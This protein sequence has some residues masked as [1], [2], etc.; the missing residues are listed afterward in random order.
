MT[1]AVAA[2]DLVHDIVS[3][4]NAPI[5]AA[6]SGDFAKYVRGMREIEQAGVK[7][8]AEADKILEQYEPVSSL[9][10]SLLPYCHP[11][12]SS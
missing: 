9:R 2:P 4:D 3:V 12:L 11:P 10:A 8:Q 5:D 1:I 7:R 6:I